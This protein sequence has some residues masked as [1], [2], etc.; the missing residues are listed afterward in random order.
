MLINSSL[1]LV[2]SSNK[3]DLSSMNTR[4]LHIFSIIC[5]L[6]IF[7]SCDDENPEDNTD[8]NT[9]ATIVDTDTID[10]TDTYRFPDTLLAYVPAPSQFMN[11]APGLPKDAQSIIGD[12]GFVTLGGWGGY[13]IVGYKDPIIN[14]PDNPYG[15]D[16]SI[17]GNAYDGSSEPG[18]VQVMKDENKNGI[19]DDTWYELKGGDYDSSLQAYALTYYN[20]NDSTVTWSNNQGESGTLLHNGYHTQSYYPSNDLYP[21]YPQDSVTFTGTLLPTKSYEDPDLGYWVNP[22]FAYGYADNKEVKWS[23]KLNQPDNP[24]TEETEGVGGDAFKLEWA[25]NAQGQRV[26]IDTVHFIKIYSGVQFENL[27]LGDISTEIRAIIA[28]K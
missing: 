24:E 2:L 19:A 4:I 27:R 26:T 6:F 23:E 12:K 14:H 8:G 17:L 13:I 22:E 11:I 9:G 25:I 10:I 1:Y 21:D 28:V 3:H 18:I 16:F 15:V 7:I 5:F 20:T